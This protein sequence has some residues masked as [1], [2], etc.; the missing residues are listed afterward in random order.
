MSDAWSEVKALAE[1][2]ANSG[3]IFVRLANNGDKVVG[4]FCGDP[5]ARQSIWLG[6]HTE[7]YDPNNPAHRGADKKPSLK[8]AVNF[9]VPAEGAMKVI[10]VG[11]QTFR[12]VARVREKFG[13]DKWLF[14]I[15]R[16][17]EAGSAKTKYSVLPDAQIDAA[18]RAKI[19][20]AELHDLEAVVSGAA[21]EDDATPRA[22]VDGPIDPATATDLIARLKLLPRHDLEALMGQLGVAR[23]RDLKVSN[24][25]RAKQLIAAFEG[26]VQGA[27]AEVDP[28]A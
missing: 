25:A 22:P 9:Y 3:G 17:G 16:R 8:V 5:Y 19:S 2:V 14:E 4:A 20:A 10:E 26:G 28:F 1:K 15:E 6:D 13:F 7:T 21:D 18:V 12:D 27:P 23:V 24:V 11:T